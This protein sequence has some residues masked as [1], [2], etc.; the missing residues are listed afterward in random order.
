MARDLYYGEDARRRLQAGVDKLADAVKITLGPKGRNVLLDSATGKPLITN[1]GVSVARE[2]KLKDI[3]EDLGAQ[4]MKEVATKTNDAVGDGTTTATLLAQA[5]INEG[6]KNTAAGANA[7]ILRRGIQ[8]AVDVTVE[9]IRKSA[10]PVET[11]EAIA[12]VAAISGAD[13]ATGE[14]IADAM[15][16]VGRDGIIALE[17]SRTMDTTLNITK[18]TQFDK[19]YLSTHMVTDQDKMEAVLDNP[20]IL[21]T[22]KKISNMQ[23]L[24]PLLEK[25]L[26]AGRKLVIVA[27]DV[28]GDALTALVVNKLKGILDSVAVKAPGF[29]ERKKALMDSF[30]VLTGGVVVREETGFDLKETTLDMLGQAERVTVAK[31][32]TIILNGAGNKEEI[33]ERIELFRKRLAAAKTE[34]EVDAARE[35]LSK[36]AGGAAVIRVGAASEIELKEKKLRIE[37]ALNATRAAMEEGIVA[38]GGVALCNA[39]PAV[40]E[41]AKGLEGDEK[42]GA[43][44]ILR[45]LEAPLKQIAENAGFD[46]SVVA[47]EVKKREPGVGF[48]AAANEYVPMI[49]AG[50]VDPAKVTR[51]AIENA[52]SVAATF[53][54]TE[55]DVI[56]PVDEAYAFK[57]AQKA[58][59]E[60]QAKKEK[61]KNQ[62]A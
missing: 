55:A 4:L 35:N 56:D 50:I 5:I 2:I 45:A 27:D 61:K 30:A 54:T 16:V 48:D 22:D 21:F 10:V 11:K 60:R 34:F 7:I 57:R 52:A 42:T 33:A 44:I 15:D 38:G 59:E 23:E 24:F 40:A 3:T 13:E 37:D 19:G 46:G 62:K 18:G 36:L 51:S 20:Y 1:D 58:W 32:R 39:V 17:E 49:E 9:S 25:V 43:M 28:E 12:Q 8:G 47:G 14:M 41:Y 53:L 31:D 26:A 29:G 6:L